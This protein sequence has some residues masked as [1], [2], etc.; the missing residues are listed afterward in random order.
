M[1]LILLHIIRK[2]FAAAQTHIKNSF[3]TIIEWVVGRVAKIEKNIVE[4][5]TCFVDAICDLSILRPI[6]YK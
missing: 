5:R 1:R 2:D 4:K 6:P 3:I